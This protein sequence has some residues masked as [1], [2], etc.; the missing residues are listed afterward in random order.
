MRILDL[1]A[2]LGGEQRRA[3]I[4]NRG[5]EYVTLDKDPR[6][7]CTITADIFDLQA[8]DLPGPWDFVWASPPCEGFSVAGMRYHWQF[9]GNNSSMPKSAHVI[10]SM[11]LVMRTLELIKAWDP[12]AWLMENPRGML[13]TLPIV[14]GYPRVTVTYCQYGLTYQKP[15]DLWGNVPGWT[16][17]P[18]CK[19][20]AKCHDRAG[21]GEHTG[22]AATHGA[23]ARA[24]VPW[25]LWAEVLDALDGKPGPPR[26]KQMEF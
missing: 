15:T 11:R 2:G 9:E 10:L 22:L 7:N 20:G 4:E 13:R 19:P 24:V 18:K 14:K 12:P 17:H 16:P 23:A 21:R 26:I 25:A 8:D 6:F 5:H 1:Y 3:A